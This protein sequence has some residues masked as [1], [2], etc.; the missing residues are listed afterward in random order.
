M[1]ERP[2]PQKKPARGAQPCHGP[3]VTWILLYSLRPHRFFQ[4]ISC[5]A[6]AFLSIASPVII[7]HQTTESRQSMAT[8]AVDAPPS[9]IKIHVAS[10]SNN[11][12]EVTEAYPPAPLQQLEQE[13][14]HGSMPTQVLEWNVAEYKVRLCKG[15]EKTILQNVVGRAEAGTFNAIL[16]P[17]GCGK[18][19]L[20]NCLALRNSSFMGALRLDGKPLNGS[21]FLQAGY[22]HQKELFFPHVT[23][24]EH[25]TFH[26][27]NRLSRIRT[28]DECKA[29]VEAVLQ[30]VDMMKV[31][32]SQIGGGDFYVFAGLSGGERKRLNIATELLADPLI[33]LLDEPNSG[34][35]NGVRVYA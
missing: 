18:T 20:L 13:G 4:V 7:L 19:S 17:S 23:V 9:S 31:G 27:I 32:D 33:L 5:L 3:D 11:D 8:H 25:L 16:G 10:N 1:R 22:V 29:R 15:G 26:A 24:R 12:D 30:E 34:T 6:I 2:P 28:P 14:A 35:K 21:F